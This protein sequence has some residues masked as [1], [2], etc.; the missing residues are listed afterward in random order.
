MP[1]RV[2][3][4][5]RIGEGGYPLKAREHVI[6]GLGLSAGVY[7]LTRDGS[8]AAISGFSAVLLDEVGN[9]LSLAPVRL[10]PMFYFLAYRSLKGFRPAAM[11][12]PRP[13]TR[14]DYAPGWKDPRE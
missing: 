11:T 6:A 10:S 9:R 3:R 5:P 7:L 13:A 12:E 14:Y 8:L 2:L 4:A 1:A